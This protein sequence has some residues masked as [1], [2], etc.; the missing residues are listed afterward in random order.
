MSRRRTL[1]NKLRRKQRRRLMMAAACAALLGVVAFGW[2]RSYWTTDQVV[3]DT[4]HIGRGDDLDDLG[5]LPWRHYQVTRSLGHTDGMVLYR[6]NSRYETWKDEAAARERAAAAATGIE[7]ASTYSRIGM[8]LYSVAPRPQWGFGGLTLSRLGY[9]KSDDV[10]LDVP[11]WMPSLLVGLAGGA[12]AALCFRDRRRSRIRCCAS[13]GY[14]LSG[15]PAG[16]P[17]PECGR[18]RGGNN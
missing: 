18:G 3:L 6:R 10:E 16:N 1:A 8:V 2:I 7:F 15:L 5:L 4:G 11:Y 17:C 14:Q 13:C 12:A 9:G